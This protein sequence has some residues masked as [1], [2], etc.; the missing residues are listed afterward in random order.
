MYA[1]ETVTESEKETNCFVR[2]RKIDERQE[3]I[4]ALWQKIGRPRKEYKNQTVVRSGR[5][6]FLGQ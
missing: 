1:E 5:S 3:Y 2:W 6:D 4:P